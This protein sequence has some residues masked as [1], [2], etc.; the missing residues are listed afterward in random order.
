M[1]AVVLTEGEMVRA[2]KDA[3]VPRGQWRI[4]V[5]ALQNDDPAARRHEDGCSSCTLLLE[6]K[7]KRR[8]TDFGCALRQRCHFN[9]SLTPLQ[10]YHHLNE[11]H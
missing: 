9:L 8:I 5:A 11:Q 1:G 4:S 6:R 7:R 10:I 2:H 3:A